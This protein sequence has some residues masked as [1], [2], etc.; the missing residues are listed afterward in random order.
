MPNRVVPNAV[1]GEPLEP[2]WHRLS[3]SGQEDLRYV[4]IGLMTLYL[5]M[6]S[7]IVAIP[8]ALGLRRL[9]YGQGRALSPAIDTAPEM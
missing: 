6:G 8:L 3:Y 4:S 2:G 7:S 5:A 9:A 1:V